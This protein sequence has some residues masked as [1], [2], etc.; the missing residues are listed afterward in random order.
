[1]LE[2][3]RRHPDKLATLILADTYA[4]WKGSLPQDEV[5]AR[6][7]GLRRMLEEPPDRFDPTLPGLFAGNPPPEF[8]SLLEEIDADVRPESMR[9]ALGVMADADLNDVL[10]TIEVPTLLIWGEQDVRS[11]LH[12]AREFHRAIP[13]AELV[14]I[15]KAGH[16]SNLEAP[17]LF[18]EAIRSFCFAHPAH[19]D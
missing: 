16:V 10:P 12:V 9:I 5:Q 3:Y 17:T 7:E 18:N 8:V 13:D 14:V 15:P 2:L 19:R 4:G 1:V 11:P 6:V